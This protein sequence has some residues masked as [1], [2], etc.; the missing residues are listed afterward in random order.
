[1]KIR[2]NTTQLLEA[3]PADRHAVTDAATDDQPGRAVL[4]PQITIRVKQGSGKQTVSILKHNHLA[5]VQMPREDEIVAVLP[6]RLPN[7][8][9]VRAQN[10]NIAIGLWGRIGARDRDRSRAMRNSRDPVVNPLASSA[11]HRVTNPLNADGP[12]VISPHCQNRG[13][14][15]Q[16][17]DKAGQLAQLGGAVNQVATQKDRVRFALMHAVNHLPTQSIGTTA[18]KMNIADVREPAGVTPRRKA[19]FADVKSEVKP[20]FQP[21]DRHGRPPYDAPL[22]NGVSSR[23][24]APAATC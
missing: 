7:A 4:M 8:R 3:P 12:V 13:L 5:A 19:F 17:T 6:R 14:L 10:P 22:H 23:S 9:V 11:D 18:A 2:R 20:E 16:L 15:A 24:H 1:M 21:G